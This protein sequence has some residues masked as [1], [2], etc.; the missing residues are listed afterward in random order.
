MYRLTDEGKM[1]L[2]KGLPEKNL[3]NA[4]LRGPL[5]IEKAQKEVEN[6]AIAIQWAKKKNWIKIK[7]N[8]LILIEY[9]KEIPEEEALRKIDRG[10]EVDESI[11]KILIQRKL[12]RK[13]TE[14]YKK[15]E[16]ELKKRGNVIGR[17][18]HDILLTGL[19]KGKKF[20]PVNIEN[21]SKIEKKVY[22][23]LQP[24]SQFLWE[25]RQKLVKLG[26][27]EMNGPIIETE[28]WNFDA[29]FQPQNHPAR[30]WTQTYQLKWP[31]YGNL[32]SQK[33]VKN[34]QRAH[35]KGIAGSCG[36]QYKW[37]RKKA[38]QL[39]PRA[40]A[41]CLSGRTLAS[42]PQIPGKYF[43]I[44]RCFR[45]DIIDPTH[46]VEFN[47]VEGIVIGKNMNFKNL[48]GILKLFAKEFVGVREVKFVPGFFPFTEPSCELHVKHPK[49]GWI[50]VA[51]AGIFREELTVPLGINVPVLA[52]G[53]GIDRLA[54][55]KLGINDIRTLFT[56][57]L[58]WLKGVVCQQ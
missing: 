23:K 52:W 37:D 56:R 42:K 18:T 5:S 17:I 34:V 16:E 27:K 57:D 7:N 15:T 24:Y 26:F 55:L 22:G 1:Y 3:V 51:G 38:S 50:E 45:P 49:F 19:W 48:L 14:V 28:F 54:M 31:K 11:L 4:L 58:M 29:L 39:M 46:S 35:E 36:W 47:Q 8:N 9:P 21:V 10:E 20:D 33:I 6:L 40:H 41:T 44:V 25:V 12:V 32:P 2:E 53:I 43:A 13:I 30:D